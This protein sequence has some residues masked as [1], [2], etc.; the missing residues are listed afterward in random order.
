MNIQ[1]QCCGMIVLL[2]LFLFYK[3]QD[4]V[5]LNTEKAY[6]RLF[7]VTVL[8][9]SMDI[10]SIIAI[11]NMSR[12]NIH[13]V[14]LVCK[15]YLATMISVALCSLSYIYADLYT[16]SGNYRTFIKKYIFI[17][18]IGTILIYTL[19]ISI[20]YESGNTDVYTYGPSAMATYGFAL[21]FV[22]INVY[23]ILKHKNRINPTRRQA[24]FIWMAVWISAAIV[25]FI[26]K[27]I[28]V[29]GY[30]FAI[31]IM[32]LYLKLENPEQN[33]DKRTGLF[34]QNAFVEYTRQLLA[35]QK[36]FSVFCLYFE[37]AF[38]N[39]EGEQ[40]GIEVTQYLKRLPETRAFKN[41][42]D[43]VVLL[44]DDIHYAEDIL[45]LLTVRFNAGW[46]EEGSVILHPYGIFIPDISLLSKVTDISSLLR[47]IR[48]N[49]Q[50]Y[51]ENYFLTV[52]ET[53][54]D[55][56]YK[57]KETE[58]LIV[59]AVENNRIEVYYQPIYSTEKRC[60][61]CAEALIRI[62]DEEGNLIYPGQFIGIAEKNG[63][64]IRMGE[65][66]FEQVCQLLSEQDLSQHGLHYIEVNLSVVQCAYSNLAEDLIFIMKKYGIDPA[67]INF[68]I[69]ESASLTAKNILLDNMKKLMDYG[70]RFS[71]DDFG[72]GHSN[73]NYVVDMPVNIVKFD[74]DMT[75][76]YFENR[77]AKFVMEAA[78]H[79]IQGMH[80]DIVSEGIETQQQFETMQNLGIQYIQGFYFSKPLKKEDFLEFLFHENQ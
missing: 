78:M 21:S 74:K 20:Y 53:M 19:P 38:Q 7:Y 4:R 56:M 80:L 36:S 12:L 47:Y 63:M 1:T 48:E 39:A 11:V 13:I 67:C 40:L 28:L 77:K 54:V 66:V 72:T 52:D 26:N 71:L 18:G 73:L 37:Q 44:F 51:T 16:R 6:L 14:N 57:E 64:I 22:L 15:T 8:S 50:K 55:D 31:G 43:E 2:V 79:M 58:Q 62:K 33:L 10:L 69:T 49:S 34:N 59:N 61:T 23:T 60:F 17:A 41:A 68:E 42:E 35:D 75:N 65:I 29:I 30:A 27:N 5:N 45:K 24:V 76:A 32:V 70:V 9:I 46:G 3:K 25:Q